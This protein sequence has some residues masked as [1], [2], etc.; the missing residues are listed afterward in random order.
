MKCL[1]SIIMPVYG[2]EKWLESA[3]RSV[4]DQ[5]ERD[6]ELILVDDCSPDGSGAL[7]DRLAREDE[8]VSVIHLRENGGLSHARNEGL[9]GA[10]GK[11]I[12]F[13]DSDDVIEPDLLKKA[14]HAAEN[15]RADWLVFG[16]TED[17]YNAKGSLTLTR[18]IV[19]EARV[20]RTQADKEEAVIAL[21]GQT[22]LGYAWNKL[23]RADF[24]REHALTFP[25]VELIE[26][27]LFNIECARYARTLVVLD[28]CG[29]HYARRTSGS[30]TGR[31]LENYFE[32]SSRRVSALL[33]LY[34]E[35]NAADDHVLGILAA[36][37]ARYVV[38]S[39]ERL[40]DP[41]R[42]LKSADRRRYVH[43]IQTQPLYVRL[44]P[45][46]RGTMGL[47]AG[48][49]FLALPAGWALHVMHTHLSGLFARLRAKTNK[50]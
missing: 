24:L 17:H 47:I 37:Y 35:W 36:I 13:M 32:L 46:F 4:L 19:P 50:I 9:S 2:V 48:S 27:I 18:R 20:C 28:E 15:A 38:S 49:F 14:V 12:F 33:A 10:E 7:C 29:Y 25:S 23:Y 26:D 3:A 34:D 8:R 11:Y 6:I 42:H 39:L 31:V 43:S 21:E 5:T 45:H 22:L 41:R 44:R 30:L 1:I 16:A 40:Y